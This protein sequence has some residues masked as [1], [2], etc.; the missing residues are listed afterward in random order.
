MKKILIL[1]HSA[2]IG[3]ANVSLLENAIFLKEEGY[4]VKIIFYQK[5]PMISRAIDLGIDSIYIPIKSIFFYGAHIKLKISMIIKFLIYFPFSYLKIKNII[6]FEKP[7]VIL[8]NTSIHLTSAIAAKNSGVSVVWYIRESLGENKFFRLWQSNI[9]KKYS[10]QIILVSNYLKKYF[11]NQDNLKTVYNSI[12]LKKYSIKKDYYNDKIRKKYNIGKNVFLICMIGSVQKVKGHFLLINLAKELKKINLDF[13]F[14]LIGA[15]SVKINNTKTDYIDRLKLF[16]KNIIHYPID[17]AD[18]MQRIIDKKNL[19]KYFSL[20][21]GKYEIPEIVS[22]TDI[23]AF[24]SMKPEGFGRPLIEGMAMGKPILAINIGPTKEIIGNDSGILIDD[25]DANKIA[26]ILLNLSK[27]NDMYNY[28][29]SNGEK[30][31]KDFFQ[32]KDLY[33]KILRIIEN[34]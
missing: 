12:D 10:D 22:A 9:I 27:N 30:R 5:G 1:Q 23:V 26:K 15:S 33:K 7:E 29:A 6:E 16:I 25:F 34:I 8:L 20:T 17:N 19:S 18:R 28:Y 14:L 11:P 24:L 3:G 4:K 21:S 32:A 2:Q 13:H 31:V